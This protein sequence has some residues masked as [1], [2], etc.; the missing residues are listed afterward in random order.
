[1]TSLIGG[2]GITIVLL[3]IPGLY[4]ILVSRDLIRILIGVELLMKPVTLLLIVAGY[5]T[6]RTGLAESL[7]ITLIVIEVVVVT[8]AAGIIIGT[9]KRTGSLDVRELQT[10]KG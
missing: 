9:F 6:G 7:V 10:M 8:V 1:M 3:L 2:F 4:C 5:V